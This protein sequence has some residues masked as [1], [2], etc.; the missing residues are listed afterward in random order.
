[1]IELEYKSEFLEVS[2][3]SENS[4]VISKWT[5]NTRYLTIDQYKQ[6][7]LVVCQAFIDHKPVFGSLAL[8][9]DFYFILDPETQ[10]WLTQQFEGYQ[11][12]KSAVVVAQEFVSQLSIEQTVQSMDIIVNYFSNEQEAREWLM[13][14]TKVSEN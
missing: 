7:V 5:P 1:M 14:Q 4:W 10:E 3:D 11:P 8:T 2:Y 6:E 9:Q 12:S 13:N